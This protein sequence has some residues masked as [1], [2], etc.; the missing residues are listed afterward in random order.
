MKTVGKTAS[1]G[2]DST[3]T[4]TSGGPADAL[5]VALGQVGLLR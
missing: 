4:G 5:E 1:G 3:T 2:S